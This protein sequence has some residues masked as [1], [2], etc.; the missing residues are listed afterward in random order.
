M[1]IRTDHK[2]GYSNTKL[3][4]PTITIDRSI[5]AIT[6]RVESFEERP[7]FKTGH[8]VAAILE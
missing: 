7:F 4:T 5:P 1:K 6:D 8:A 2:A 3:E